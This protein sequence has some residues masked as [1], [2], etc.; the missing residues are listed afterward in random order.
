[1]LPGDIIVY[2][3]LTGNT[4]PTREEKSV[5]RRW[6]ESSVLGNPKLRPGD[7]VKGGLSA[8]RKTTEALGTGAALAAIHVET[9]GGLDKFGVPIDGVAGAALTIGSAIWPNS[10]VSGDARDIGADALTVWSFRKTS[11]L[12]IE[13][14]IAS[15]RAVPRH[16]SPANRVMS[17]ERSNAAG[18]DP[19]VDAARAL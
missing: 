2:D 19:I 18:E 7:H 16:L 10:E 12:L 4:I 5:M 15:G 11:D 13:K 3:S 14:R 9:E 1:M 8:F 17:E 6:F